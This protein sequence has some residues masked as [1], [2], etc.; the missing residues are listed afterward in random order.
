MQDW[1]KLERHYRLDCPET[2][3]MPADEF[4][5]LLIHSFIFIPVIDHGVIGSFYFTSEKHRGRWL[6]LTGVEDLAMLMTVT[7]KDYPS[8]GAFK[9]LGNG[10]TATWAGHG[11]PP[12]HFPSKNVPRRTDG[13]KI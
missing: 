8:S 1:E 9:R 7:G 6:W 11:E 5:G 3:K 2:V 13:E 12:D 4:C 10:R